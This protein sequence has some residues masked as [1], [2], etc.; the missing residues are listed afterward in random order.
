MLDLA[1]RGGHIADGT[2]KPIFK[3]EVGITGDRIVEIG[4]HVSNANENIDATGRI[5][6]PGFIDVHSHSDVTLLLDSL[7]QSKVRQGVTTEVI[8]NCGFG[9]APIRPESREKLMGFW[10]RSGSEW[11]GL[12]PTWT[13]MD[14][15]LRALEEH[16]VSL[17]V[18]CLAAHGTIRFF[19]MEEDMRPATE[20]DVE[21][22]KRTL[23]KCMVS[24]CWGISTGLR[25]KPGV[26][27][28]TEEVIELC[29]V[30][31]RYGGV[32]T[33][34]LRSE[35]DNGEWKDAVNE[36]IEIAKRSGISLQISHLKALTRNVWNTSPEILKI[37]S[38][39]KKNGLDLHADQYP[40][41]ATETGIGVFL[42]SSATVAE[43]PKLADSR[44]A[45]VR[46]HVA[47]I[48]ELRGGPERITISI[49][50][51]KKEYEGQSIKEISDSL[52]IAPADCILRIMIETNGGAMIISQSMLE[53]DILRIMRTEYVM[54]GSD[55][56]SLSPK[57]ILGVGSP[58]PRSYGTFPR[59]LGY[60]VRKK[61]TLPL[62]EAVRKMTSLPANKFGFRNRGVIKESAYADL[63]VFDPNTVNDL[64]TF[65]SPSQ[66]PRGI[67]YVIVNGD[68]VVR[69]ANHTGA[70]PG[71]VLR[72]NKE[73]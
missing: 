64:S 56:Y 40:Y 69:E 62:E 66:Y 17:N 30:A 42:P 54:I 9:V 67:E 8:G 29:K 45:E 18:A 4:G 24:G 25:Y 36:A 3:G 70:T 37:C 19:V 35:G 53:E 71:K 68:L 7:A 31:A 72:K 57:G 5:V 6:C 1:I 21:L 55:G 61:C 47:K 39:A 26:Y 49:C 51:E 33:T 65:S 13:T 50:L 15:Y 43:L 2:G 38:T 11:Y 10:K 16:Q 46:K 28:K 59:I 22:M 41:D 34:H 58:H 73:E 32:Y 23:D 20:A 52:K 60:Y 12:Q 14:D 27:S 48:L 63:V 44:R